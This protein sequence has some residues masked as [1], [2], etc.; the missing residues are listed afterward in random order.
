ME[1]T[2]WNTLVNYFSK[3]SVGESASKQKIIEHIKLSYRVYISIDVYKAYLIRAGYL[4]SNNNG[5]YTLLK[6]I[7][8]DLQLESVRKQIYG[9]QLRQR[10]KRREESYFGW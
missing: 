5:V 10:K 9:P 7:P 8:N 2:K 1:I 3:L 4:K 6:P